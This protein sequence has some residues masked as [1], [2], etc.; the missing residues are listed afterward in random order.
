MKG[1]AAAVALVVIAGMQSAPAPS[2]RA[3][4]VIV[5]DGLRADAVTPET[6][7]R[8]S[9]LSQR[10]IAFNAHHSVFP[11]VTRVNGASLVTGAY[12]ETHGL[13]GNT[14]YV[15]TVEPLRGLDTGQRENLER[16]AATEKKLLTAPTLS[17]LLKAAGK[18]LVALGSGTTGA[19]FVL[20]DTVASGAVI[21]P[22]YARP[23]N[24]EARILQR[25]GP[26]P[27]AAT[28]NTARHQR[29]VD[30]YLQMV[31]AEM[32]PDVTVIWLN[33]P[34]ETGHAKGM[35]AATREAIEIVDREIGRVEDTL[36]DR[37]LL[38]RTNIIVT[39]DHGFSTYANTLRLA[40]IVRPLAQPMADGSPDVVV[41]EGAIYFRGSRDI[42]RQRALV[43]VLQ[44]KPEVGA[45]FTTPIQDRDVHGFAEGTLSLDVARW[46]HARSADILVSPNWSDDAN[47]AGIKGTSTQ[48]GTAGHGS[49][50][51]YDIHNIL[52]A[53]GPDF[54]EHATS[55][56]PT[57]NV[58][59]AP[60][61]LHLLGMPVAPA[62]TG[63]VIAEGLKNGPLPSSVAVTHD[64]QTVTTLD[65]SYQ[66]SAHIS[67][68]MG[69]RYLDYTV[70]NRK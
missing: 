34:D 60:T 46:R 57:S 38:E 20:N 52:F 2:G 15:P 56:V 14:V 44:K 35:G 10:G 3:Q 7:P 54:R 70:A 31:L 42:E 8:L 28:P 58:D 23:L 48:T 37:G 16:I 50:S 62:M 5:V 29:I 9:R 36:R 17:E 59:L 18:S 22:Q 64:T 19:V 24:L 51:P 21:H 40:E 25:F 41:A 33:D 49:S 1:I 69:K 67:I 32:R 13:L 66:V 47:G 30:T 61:L 4:L 26:P 11:T 68:A 53:A 55:A 12:P 43:R 45:I 27:A 6:M 65:G 63:R 39:S